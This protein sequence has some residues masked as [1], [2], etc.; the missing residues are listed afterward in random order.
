MRANSLRF[1]AASTLVAAIGACSSAMNRS[2][3]LGLAVA[4][5][6]A[7]RSD[8]AYLASDKLEGRL[9]GTPGNDSA[10]AYIARRYQSLR[11]RPAYPGYLQKFVARSA[12]AVHSG[13]TVGH[14]TQN[15]VA[16]LKGSDPK[17]AGQYIVIGAHFDHLGN[18]T[19]FSMDPEAKDA[20]RNG[21]DDNASGT[22]AVLQLARMLSIAKPKRSVIFANFSGEEEGLLGSEYFV[23]NPPV[24][25][26]SIM[27]MINFDMVG[28]LK[29]QKLL[30]YGTGTATELAGLLDSA[31]LKWT[32]TLKV[33][34]SG[35]GFGSSDQSS[36]YAKNIPVLHF[37]TDIHDDYHRASDDVEK[38]NAGGEA[39]VIDLA[40]RVIRAIDE[41]PSRL[42]FVKSAAP[43]RLGPSSS[44][45]QAYL[46]SVPNMSAGTVPGLKLSGVRAGSPA[47]RG[48]LKADDIIVEFGGVPVTDLQ[49]YSDALYSHKPGDIVK[50][51]FL[52]DGKKLEANVTLG[53]RGG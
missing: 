26:D 4:D 35:D 53:T 36:F 22:A 2:P 12:A 32:P 52:R 40:Y 10:A 27:A 46:G 51:V 41:R 15:V 18:Q 33:Q 7:I 6:A 1:L 34:G 42:T 49:S 17:L 39:T 30:V 48:G 21:A 25:L 14:P 43:A 3:S 5:S 50:I 19:Q 24:P 45:S 44:G 29:D 31:T 8:I 20:I 38:I 37:F 16:I 23:S 9:T 13:D 28:R 47:E 11:L